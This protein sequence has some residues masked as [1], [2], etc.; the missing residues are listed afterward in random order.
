MKAL[1][2]ILIREQTLLFALPKDKK[3]AMKNIFQRLIPTVLAFLNIFDAYA[4]NYGLHYN[5]IEESNPLMNYIWH[6]SP[7]LFINIKIALSV[8][9]LISA[10]FI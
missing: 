10:S 9:L 4:T 5:L 8:L 7:I 3:V 2:V 6:I 1:Q